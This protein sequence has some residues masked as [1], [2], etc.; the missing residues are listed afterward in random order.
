MLNL[1]ALNQRQRRLSGT[2]P[3]YRAVV[4]VCWALP[5]TLPGVGPLIS[6]QDPSSELCASKIILRHPDILAIALFSHIIFISS[7]GFAEGKG[8]YHFDYLLPSF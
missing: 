3:T 1:L 7:V 2:K 8:T 5:E 4:C 6:W